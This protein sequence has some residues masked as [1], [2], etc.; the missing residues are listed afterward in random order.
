[1]NGIGLKLPLVRSQTDGAFELV[2]N[3]RDE[4]RQ[5]F[6]NLILTSPGERIMIPDFGVGIRNFLFEQRSDVT[7]KITKKI[8]E[9]V[10]T[11]MPYVQIDDI[12]FDFEGDGNVL[13]EKNILSIRI[14]FQVPNFG[15]NSTILIDR[16]G[17]AESV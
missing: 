15:L 7:S 10:D 4:I 8:H 5:N 11:Y 1:M 3:F 6:K 14:E 2:K 16:A 12:L 13:E 9:Q 17:V